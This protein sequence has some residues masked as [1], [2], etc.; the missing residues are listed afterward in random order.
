MLREWAESAVLSFHE[1]EQPRA[2]VGPPEG[3]WYWRVRVEQD[4]T[5]GPW[6][7][8]RSFYLNRP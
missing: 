3:W 5:I 6:S 8:I 2:G 7:A 4:G 1:Q